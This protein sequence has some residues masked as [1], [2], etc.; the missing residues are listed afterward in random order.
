MTIGLKYCGGCNPNY[1]RRSVVEKAKR[2]YPDIFFEPYDAGR[3]YDIVLV[4]CGCLEECF[5]FVCQ[6]SLH[7]TIYIRSLEEYQR[8]REFLQKDY[9]ST[10]PV[11]KNNEGEDLFYE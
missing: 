8:L 11:V 1:E 2:E 5:T 10:I 4:I 6:N 7:G 9:F 3:R